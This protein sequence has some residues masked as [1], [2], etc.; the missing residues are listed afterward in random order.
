MYPVLVG[1]FDISSAWY[2]IVQAVLEKGV[3]QKLQAYD[4]YALTVYNLL[5]HIEHPEIR[6][7]ACAEAGYTEKMLW[8]YWANYFFIGVDSEHAHSYAKRLK[9][10]VDQYQLVANMLR[11]TPYSRRA[12]MVISK[13]EDLLS[14]YAPCV[15]ELNFYCL[16]PDYDRVNLTVMMRSWDVYSAGNPDLASFQM[17]NEMVAKLADKETGALTVLATNAHIY[18]R[19]LEVLA[20]KKKDDNHKTF[21]QVMKEVK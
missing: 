11:E 1:A 3:K 20:A 8:D 21:L 17:A 4:E 13:P 6:P 12:V 14:E 7:M 2:R 19:T 10:P 18:K 9:E 15:R 16:P 5:V